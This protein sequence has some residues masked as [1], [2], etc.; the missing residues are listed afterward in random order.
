MVRMV[1]PPTR[2]PLPEHN[3]QADH[4][5]HHSPAEGGRRAVAG[6]VDGTPGSLTPPGTTRPAVLVRVTARRLGGEALLVACPLVQES[7]DGA[8]AEPCAIAGALRD[9]SER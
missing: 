7:L 8:I 1:S 6:M 4:D 5:A 9:G 2:P 3:A